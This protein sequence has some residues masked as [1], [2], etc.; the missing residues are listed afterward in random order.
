MKSVAA[1]IPT[2]NHGLLLPRAIES[3]LQ[4]TH[5]V[6]EI[7]VLDDG[8]RD[9]TPEVV[10]PYLSRIRYVRQENRG[11]SAARN[12]AIRLATS[13]W[14][15][16]LDADDYWLPRKIAAQL[17]TAAAA[18]R[19]AL[20]YNT[21]YLEYP[22][23]QRLLVP[24]TPI[25]QLWPNLR[26]RNCVTGSGSA[27]LMKRA[28]AIDA[29]LFDEGLTA[30][31]DW[32]LWIR[33]AVTHEF[34]CVQEPLAVISELPGSMSKHPGRMLENTQ[35]I[36]DRS[37]LLGLRGVKRRVWRRRIWAAALY[38]AALAARHAPGA[39]ARRFLL[40]SLMHWPSPAFQ[41]GRWAA[42]GS[43]VLRPV[44]ARRVEL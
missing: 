3:V 27:V 5:A 4:Q 12:A 42:L 28:E 2:Y 7:I 15:A 39:A 29:G 38:S 23:G 16:L 41:P 8:S 14:I 31:E 40:Q 22:Q 21:V 32:D 13:E 9:N 11:L 43:E 25:D 35:R 1:I 36:M 26:F 37:L 18:P 19:A 20:V 6:T 30:C 34:A 10:V 24:A 33:L 17:A 44:V